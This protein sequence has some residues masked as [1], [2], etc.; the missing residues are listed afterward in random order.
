AT[1]LAEIDLAI[2]GESARW[3]DN[4]NP[5]DPYTREDFLRV[6]S[7]PSGDG[8]AV[9]T[10]FFPTRT[11]TVLGQFAAAG[12]LPTLPA[13]I[14][15]MDGGVVVSGD[16]IDLNPAAGSPTGAVVYYTLDG[17][18]P[19]LP[20]GGVSP[21]AVAAEGAVQ[22]F[23]E[24]RLLART[25]FDATGTA[26][27]WSPLVDE[28]FFMTDGFPLRI[29][30]LYY[31]PETVEEHEFFELLNTGSET[32]SLDGVQIEDFAV[33][34]YAFP[35]G[36][37]LAAGERIVVARNPDQFVSRFGAGVNLAPTGYA[38]ANLSNGGELLTLR[39]PLGEILQ[40]FQYDDVAPWPEAAD[41]L[42]A[43]LEYVGPFVVGDPL[44]GA[45]EDP[46]DD[47]ANWRAS[48]ETGGTP[49]M[50]GGGISSDFNADGYVDG[51]DFLAWQR[52]FGAVDATHD[53]GDSNRDGRVD[54]V[55]FSLWEADFGTTTAGS[56]TLRSTWFIPDLQ[57]SSPRRRV[58]RR[59]RLAS[60]DD[61]FT[62]W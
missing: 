56:S 54:G 42:G 21:N 49:G 34:P 23:D 13:P 2:M 51:G 15:G 18:D 27:D 30:E 41:G 43:S 38:E 7:D 29:V 1:R 44:A 12:W 3:G 25:F 50:A 17:S 33:E 24:S 9:L 32:I 26:N 62:A 45:P 22:I 35:A 20:G 60:L 39:G 47:P 48:S 53:D 14:L 57:A 8:K 4:R 6:N 46:F 5:T 61:A 37:T 11:S 28:L 59:D 16:S 40:Q 19:R 10:D 58:Q 36:L 52:G 55:D 31:H